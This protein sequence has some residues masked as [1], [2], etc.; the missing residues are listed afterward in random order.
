VRRFASRGAR[1]DTMQFVI[2]R[3]T[4]FF[5]ANELEYDKVKC[6]SLEV[7]VEVVKVVLITSSVEHLRK[8]ID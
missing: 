2:V 6:K 5:V 3:L 7:V 1:W 8:K 4:F